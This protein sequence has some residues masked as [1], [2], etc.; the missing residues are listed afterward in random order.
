MRRTALLMM[1]LALLASGCAGKMDAKRGLS[2]EWRLRSLEENFLNF[3]EGQREQEDKAS[4]RDRKVQERLKALEDAVQRMQE[5]GVAMRRPATLPEPAP[6]LAS[7]EAPA[8]ASPAPVP[9][10]APARPAPAPKA[11][12]MPKPTPVAK[13]APQPES[14][15]ASANGKAESGEDKPWAEVPSAQMTQPEPANGAEPVP[16]PSASGLSGTALY[17]KGM[18]EVRTERPEAAVSGRALLTEFLTAEPNSALVPNALY[19]IGESY[20]VEKNYAQAILSLKDVT[21]RF[22]RHHKAAAALLKI[23]M[24]Y[25]R[26]GEKDN[27]ALYLRA[28]VQD[29]PRSEPAPAARKL[30]KELGR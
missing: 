5:G 26:M 1:T 20:F 22:P 14:A 8:P 4:E 30:L 16:V 2:E 19:W 27:A 28:L 10:P 13:P 9:P 17:N 12:P 24:A 6:A 21:R 18:T 15:P 3:K 29:H 7:A 25:Q 11:K 23:G